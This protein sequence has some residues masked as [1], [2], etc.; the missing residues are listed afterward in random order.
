VQ[1]RQQR[2]PDWGLRGRACLVFA[3]SVNHTTPPMTSE[4]VSTRHLDD[5]EAMQ[6][7]STLSHYA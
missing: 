3:A 4:I 7:A 2:R 5:S 6:A 1:V